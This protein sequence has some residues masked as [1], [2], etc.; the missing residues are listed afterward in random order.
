MS[1]LSRPVVDGR[2]LPAQS[3]FA[4]VP[5]SHLFGSPAAAA[6]SKPQPC[7]ETTQASSTIV[8][9]TPKQVFDAEYR[10]CQRSHE[11]K[12]GALQGLIRGA[13]CAQKATSPY[14]SGTA[15]DDAWRAGLLAGMAEGKS[16]LQAGVF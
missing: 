1:H 16:L 10:H 7:V 6:A 11:W 4:A 5:D 15:Q 14:Q 3:G 8:K 13:G 2:T 12:V 9:K